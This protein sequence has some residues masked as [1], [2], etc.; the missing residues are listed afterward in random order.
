[1]P[2]GCFETCCLCTSTTLIIYINVS[3]PIK[4]NWNLNKLTAIR[5]P[6]FPLTYIGAINNI[7]VIESLL[8]DQQNYQHDLSFENESTRTT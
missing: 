1:M 5:N 8:S 4:N 3:F 6:C 2:S 7:Y